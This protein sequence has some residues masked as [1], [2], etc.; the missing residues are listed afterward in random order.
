MD[1]A[2]NVPFVS[3]QDIL[4]AII[5]YGAI[6]VKDRVQHARVMETGNVHYL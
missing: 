1:V 2:V 3:T 6:T 5:E 4:I